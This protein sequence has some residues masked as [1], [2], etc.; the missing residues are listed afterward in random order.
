MGQMHEEQLRI[1][2]IIDDVSCRVEQV[3]ESHAMS[4]VVRM[5]APFLFFLFA[6]YAFNLSI[7]RPFHNWDMVCYIA[8]AKSFEERDIKS[9]HVF[10]FDQLRNSVSDATYEELTRGN[11]RHEISANPSAF[12]NLLPFYQIRPVYTGLIYLLYK[13]GVNIGF[14]THIISGVAIVVAIAFLYLMSVS[15]LAKPLVY[16][17]PPLAYILGI[18][19]LARLSTPDGMAALAVILSAYLYLKKRITLLLI[20]LPIMLGVRT[21]LILFTI[22]LLC[23]IFLFERNSRWKTVLLI[24]ISI[25]IYIG[26]GACWEN[27]GWTTIFRVT[28][29][30]CPLQ[31][32]LSMPPTL[33]T[34][35]Y[36]NT[37]FNEI[38]LL[39]DNKLLVLYVFVVA[40]S[41]Y[42]IK[43][44]AK[45]T[46][47]F[48]ALKS[49]SA[50]LAV[51][52]LVFVAS[53]FIAFPVAWD[54]F[55]SAPYLIGVFSLMVM[56]TQY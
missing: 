8:A 2:S 18:L 55:F 35:L 54:R 4:L 44:Y 7:Y 45:T 16:A 42:L 48:V 1:T 40:Y 17:M 14:A 47:L 22:P 3:K 38:K 10:A 51:V 28:L 11:F 31:H 39:A 25:A 41:L 27:P 56:M 5:L 13:T 19:D 52:C 9:L 32:P 12:K 37:L 24:L 15:F 30:P 43:N 36:L 53:H 26:I 29:L 6:A 50:V 33:T 46:S 23:L 20:I 21:D 34:R 49:S